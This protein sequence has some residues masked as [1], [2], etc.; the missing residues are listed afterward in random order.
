MKKTITLLFAVVM[1]I[2]LNSCGGSDDSSNNSSSS[3]KIVGTWRYAGDIYGGV[4]EPENYDACDDEFLK[5][6][7]NNTG[8]H[9]EKYCGEASD[10]NPFSW[11]K[12]TNSPYN[13][14]ILDLD[15]GQEIEQIVIFSEDF[16]KFTVYETEELMLAEEGGEVY[17]KQ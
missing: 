9:T 17:E 10:V 15:F 16:Q 4:F 12:I 1:A 14:S 3:D 8:K 11:E 5:F 13:Y 2:S 6:S 7:A